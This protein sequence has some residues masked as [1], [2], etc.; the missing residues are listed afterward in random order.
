M[1]TDFPLLA[2]V[3][4]ASFLKSRRRVSFYEVE[5]PS[6]R[7]AFLTGVLCFSLPQDVPGIPQQRKVT[8]PLSPAVTGAYFF[9]YSRLVP[10]W[11]SLGGGSFL[12][13]DLNRRMASPFYNEFLRRLAFDRTGARAPVR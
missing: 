5:I 1:A 10:L 12:L 9:P 13:D 8:F 11:S 7:R 3:P 6:D 4:S 2:A